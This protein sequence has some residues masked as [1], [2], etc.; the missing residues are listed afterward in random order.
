MTL[1]E[2]DAVLAVRR[3]EGGFDGVDV[4]FQRIN[5]ILL[6]LI[7]LYYYLRPSSVSNAT[8]GES[9][10]FFGENSENWRI[11]AG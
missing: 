3:K 8:M 2:C 4:Q 5:F 11:G 9:L 7:R 10:C 1:G 6:H